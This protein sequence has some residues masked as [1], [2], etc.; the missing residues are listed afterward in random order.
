MTEFKQIIGRGT[1]V[2]DDN[3]KLYFNILDYTGSAT[4]MFADPEFDGEPALAT[5]VEIDEHGQPVPGTEEVLQPEEAIEEDGRQPGGLGELDFGDEPHEPRKYYADGGQVAIAAHLVYELDPDGKKLRVVQYSDYA[6]EKV[7]TLYPSAA[8][9]RSK[10]ADPDQRAE[11]IAKLEE[12]GIAFDELASAAN[13]PDADPF[14]LLC[15]LAFNAPLRT[16]RERA[17]R[18]RK[19]K[20]DFFEQFGIE[21]RAILEEL[22]E[23]YAEHGT[24]QFVLP[25]VLEVPPPSAHGNVME[26]AKKFGG[27]EKL[28]DA[29]HQL[30]TLLYAA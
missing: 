1:R 12:R 16:R 19:E 20:K 29:V 23:K 22:V 27:S 6:A 9:L 30:Q 5:Q 26:I 7:R 13:Q 11:I 3:G 2:R 24:A 8:E 10:W 18:L 21:A 14:D 4:R 28:V 17:E 25:D 15:H